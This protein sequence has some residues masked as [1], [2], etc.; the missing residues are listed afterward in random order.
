MKCASI[1]SLG[2]QAVSLLMISAALQAATPDI[3]GHWELRHDSRSVPTAS[4][5]PAARR[6]IALHQRQ[7]LEGLRYCRTVGMPFMMDGPLNIRQGGRQI[8]IVSPMPAT[9]RHLYTDGRPMVDRNDFE[10]TSVGF[11]VARWEG[12]ALVVETH[13]FSNKGLVS[14]PGGGYRTPNGTLVERLQLR[15]DGQRLTVRSTWTD[16]AVFVRPHSYV[17]QYY[18]VANTPTEWSCDPKDAARAEFFAPA[19]RSLQ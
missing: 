15:A 13:G 8:V 9:A 16:S 12:D 7:D 17:F 1:T 19:I 2:P 3:S 6:A 11:S 14:I 10:S 5:T 4:L 18:R